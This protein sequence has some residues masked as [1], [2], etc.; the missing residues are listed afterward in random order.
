MRFESGIRVMSGALYAYGNEM[1][2]YTITYDLVV[3]NQ[4]YHLQHHQHSN[5]LVVLGGEQMKCN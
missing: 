1:H 4:K 2:Y 3:Q 5:A